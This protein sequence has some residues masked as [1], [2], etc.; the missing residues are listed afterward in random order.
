MKE[1]LGK[2]F[3]KNGLEIIMTILIVIISSIIFWLTT[4]GK[5]ESID[6]WS[7]LTKINFTRK[8]I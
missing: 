8:I 7:E 3:K 6:D 2:W 5:I 1:K 4:I